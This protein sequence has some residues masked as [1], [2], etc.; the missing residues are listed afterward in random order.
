VYINY[1]TAT[2]LGVTVL[3]FIFSFIQF[4]T[5]VIPLLEIKREKKRKARKDYVNIINEI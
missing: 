5:V 1:S 4:N 3:M 2:Y